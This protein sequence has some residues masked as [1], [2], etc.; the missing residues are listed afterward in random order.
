[1]TL[2][3]AHISRLSRQHL[4]IV[5]GRSSRARLVSIEHADLDFIKSKLR[6]VS[7]CSWLGSWLLGG[8]STS[9]LW[10]MH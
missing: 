9:W 5:K 7:W 4:L 10:H 1:M 2:F 6:H 8:G 3:D